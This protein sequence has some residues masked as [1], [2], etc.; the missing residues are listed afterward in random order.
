MFSRKANPRVFFD[1]AI[2]GNSAGK[3]TF[4]LSADVVPKT[5]ENFRKLCKGD[6]GKGKSGVELWYKG[7]SFHRIIPGFMCQGGDFTKHNGTGG[8]SIYGEEF[9]DENFK[10]KHKSAGLL[11]M[12]NKGK[13]TNG[14]QFF[15]TT[16]PCP[17]LDGKH[18]VFGKLI[19]G[20]ELLSKIESYGSKSGT[21]IKKVII[22]DCGE[23]DSDDESD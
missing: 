15:I 1:I 17:W 16:V 22:E 8:E 18:V 3:L 21:P 7:S 2:D 9:N 6:E 20:N 5:V 12:A 13:N 11:S 14:S 4:E 10:L 23:V 19:N